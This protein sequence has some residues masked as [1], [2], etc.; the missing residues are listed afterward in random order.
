MVAGINV[1][2]LLPSGI[3]ELSG[4][5]RLCLGMGALSSAECFGSDDVKRRE[6]HTAQSY[7]E[8]RGRLGGEMCIHGG[9]G[10]FSL[11]IHQK[12]HLHYANWKWDLSFL[13]PA[14]GPG[15]SPLLNAPNSKPVACPC[16]LLSSLVHWL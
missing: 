14:G 10:A 2:L 13:S 7:M 16:P 6:M 11:I 8:A 1:S 9:V 4:I 3:A 12:S 15:S 5:D